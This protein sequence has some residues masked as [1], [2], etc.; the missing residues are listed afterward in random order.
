MSRLLRQVNYRPTVVAVPVCN[1]EERI[2]ACIAA[3]SEQEDVRADDI[4]LLVNNTSDRT[5]AVAQNVRLHGSTRLHILERG[6]PPEAA[7]A[8]HARRL[9]MRE[10]AGLA[11][12]S[13]ILLTTDAD[14][15]PDPDWLASNLA[16]IAQGVDA[17]AGWVD[18]D[19]AEWS[20]IPLTLHEADARECAYDS[21]CDEIEAHLDPDPWDPLPRHTQNSGASI[22]VTVAAYRRA[23]GIPAA[24]VG[25]D[26]AFLAALRRIDARIRHSPACHVVVSGRTE[27]RAAGGMADTIR[28]RLRTPDLLIDERL[29]PASDCARRADLRRR[30]RGYYSDPTSSST[31]V[32]SLLALDEGLLRQ[33]SEQLTFGT[34]WTDVEEMSPR[35]RRRRVA[36]ADLAAEMAHASEIC[37]LLRETTARTSA[38]ASNCLVDLAG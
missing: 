12:P 34:A 4:V 1:E 11:G 22:A 33:A 5:V 26:R 38:A 30:F 8:G 31:E 21:L 14:S 23:G 15:R 6:L 9:A 2:A 13:G 37:A 24:V 29:E 20:A 17:V 10:A 19:P 27:G 16:E 18:L 28:R 3:I 35:L 7:G 25:E 32:A 36:V